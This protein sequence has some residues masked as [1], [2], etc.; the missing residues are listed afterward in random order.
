VTTLSVGWLT[1]SEHDSGPLCGAVD[2]F[3]RRA[4][5]SFASC[6]TYNLHMESWKL[7]KHAIAGSS[8]LFAAVVTAWVGAWVNAKMTGTPLNGVPGIIQ[9]WKGVFLGPVPVWLVLILLVSVVSGCFLWFTWYKKRARQGVDLR[10]VVLSTPP[11]RW[12]IGAKAQVPFMSISFH[13]QMA[14]MAGHS[15]QIVKGY[16]EGTECVAP[17]IPLVVAGPHDP[18]TMV[19]F[20][21]RPILAHDGQ[22]VARR[23]VLVDQ[24]GN[25][26]RTERIRFEPSSQPA[27]RFSSGGNAVL[28][29]F[30]QETI[31]AEELSEAS[32]VPAHKACIK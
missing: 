32:A 11:P 8:A 27:T 6:P 9:F 21:V 22:S 20:G 10:I 30:C 31:A 24:F 5:C 16:L 12:H 19:H 14:H 2:S 13:A 29:W 15:L 7:R 26:H 1:G 4:K 17:F 3:A 25:K 18:S 23:V 28:C